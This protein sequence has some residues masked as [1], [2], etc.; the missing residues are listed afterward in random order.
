MLGIARSTFYASVLGDLG[1][2]RLGRRRLV[3]VTELE[4][5]IELNAERPGSIR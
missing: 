5:W 4:R 1:V 2:V 3:P